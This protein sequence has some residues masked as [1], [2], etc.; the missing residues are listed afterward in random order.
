MDNINKLINLLDNMDGLDPDAILLEL[1]ELKTGGIADD[2]TE[3]LISN[4]KED[5]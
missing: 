3:L 2:L 4:E 1:W 5:L